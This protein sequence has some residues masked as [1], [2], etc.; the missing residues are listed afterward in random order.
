LAGATETKLRPVK[1]ARFMKRPAITD[2]THLKGDMPVHRTTSRFI[3]AHTGVS[4]VAR[5]AAVPPSRRPGASS[6][7][8]N[9]NNL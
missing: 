8:P 9:T 2:L 1:P 6:S 3:L 7:Q 5:R 4:C